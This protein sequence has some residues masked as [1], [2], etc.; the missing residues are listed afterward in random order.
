MGI[1]VF[2]FEGGGRG[3]SPVEPRHAFGGKDNKSKNQKLQEEK[4]MN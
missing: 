3:S 4:Q 1:F 2:D